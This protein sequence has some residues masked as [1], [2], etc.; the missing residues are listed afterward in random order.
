MTRTTLTRRGFAAAAGAAVAT[1]S[2]GV[3]PS[4]ARAP[5][6][7]ATQPSYHRIK[8]GAFEV[9]TVFDGSAAVP[10]VHPIF[11]QNQSADA[12]GAHMKANLL[13]A[14]RMTIG[15]TPVIVNTGSQLV[16]F[17]TG[18]GSGRGATR[19]HL[20]KAVA[21]AGYKPEQIDIVV[22]THFHPDHIGGL[23]V[24]GKPQY[25]NARY[26]TS[27]AEY[28]FWSKQDPN[29]S[30]TTMAGRAKLV[31]AQ[32]VPLA[33]QMAF[34]KDGADVV[35]G[36]TAVGAYGHTPGHTAFNIESN[37]QRVLL[38][39]DACNHYVASLQ[40]PEWHV[41]FDM[42]KDAAIASRKKILG[43]VAADKIAATGY[44]MPF[45]AI[46]YVEAVG[47]AFRWV[48]ATYQFDG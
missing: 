15:F 31:Q 36:I 1:A 45:P 32:V 34:I 24:D 5:M 3:Q 26:V 38:W 21:A 14:D 19:G 20:A 30:D 4:A 10:K 17:D 7:G 18:N 6:F 25:P 16:L 11:G 44:H 29:S 40:K 12:V 37:G 23:L 27:E 46:G 47:D 42:D 9:T 2:I 39:A 48:P 13:P 8:L 28:N 41:V 33:E 43:M 22:L 35:S